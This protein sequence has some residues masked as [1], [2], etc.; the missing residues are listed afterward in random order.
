MK[1]LLVLV[2]ALVLALAAVL[3]VLVLAFWVI[4]PGVKT[5]VGS[6]GGQLPAAGGQS[7]PGGGCVPAAEWG[8]PNPPAR[9]IQF[10]G[11]DCAVPAAL[12]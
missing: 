11:A 9:Y 4:A 3:G 1:K 7:V 10:R 6:I 2:L 8:G 5:A 12:A